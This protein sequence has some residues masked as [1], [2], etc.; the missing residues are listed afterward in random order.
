MVKHNPSNSPFSVPITPNWEGLMRCLKRAGTPD[1]VY[2]I[3]LLMDEEMRTAIAER[4]GLLEGL[5]PAAPSFACQ[6]QL[7]VQR[8]LGYDFVRCG[9]DDFDL[10]LTRLAIDDTAGLER[11]GG[12][13][14]VN[15]HQGP[16]TT[17][18]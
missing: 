11:S 9:L 5:D 15:E 4:F 10:Q 12:R 2:F 18:D 6:R 14:F 17:W 8:F 13:K 16:I 7:A 1:R 3:E